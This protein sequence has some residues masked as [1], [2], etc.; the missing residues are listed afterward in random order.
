MFHE[1]LNKDWY[2]AK[3]NNAMGWIEVKLHSYNYKIWQPHP[4]IFIYIWGCNLIWI[5]ALNYSRKG[6][7]NNTEKVQVCK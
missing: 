2:P 7:Q 6:V 4:N 1:I 3:S 5:T